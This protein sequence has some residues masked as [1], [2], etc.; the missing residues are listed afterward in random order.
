MTFSDDMKYMYLSID[1]Y[2]ELKKLSRRTFF[3]HYN[4]KLESIKI[5]GERKKI[6]I[7]TTDFVK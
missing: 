5:K 3:R 7:K 6:K 1:E 2:C 4:K